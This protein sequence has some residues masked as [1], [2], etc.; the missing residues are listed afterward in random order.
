MI[1]TIIKR[2][3]FWSRLLWPSIAAG[4]SYYQQKCGSHCS[5]S[6]GPRSWHWQM[7]GLT[8]PDPHPQRATCALCQGW[9]IPSSWAHPSRSSHRARLC[10]LIVKDSICGSRGGHIYCSHST[11]QHRIPLI[12]TNEKKD[13]KSETPFCWS[14]IGRGDVPLLL[15]G[16]SFFPSPGFLWAFFPPCPVSTLSTKNLALVHPTLVS[17]ICEDK[18]SSTSRS[19]LAFF[20][21]DSSSLYPS[22]ILTLRADVQTPCVSS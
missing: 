22:A 10:L 9:S 12:F 21:L 1:M 19:L 3:L 7:L 18:F 14:L 15:F 11:H 8:E 13:T 20:F 5:R 2:T 4:V 6:S 17:I 16:V